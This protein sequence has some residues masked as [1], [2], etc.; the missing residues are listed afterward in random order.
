MDIYIDEYGTAHVTEYWDMDTNEGTENY[1]SYGNLGDSHISNFRVSVGNKEFEP[2]TYWDIDETFNYK[3]YKSG[4][5]HTSEGL[6]LCWGISEYGNMQYKLTYEISN[7]VINVADAQMIYWTLIPKK[8]DPAPY[9]YD[10]TIR[11][12]YYFEDSIDV[13]GYGVKGDYAYV[14]NGE[15]KLSNEDAM[16][17]SEYVVLLAKIPSGTFQTSSDLNNNFEYYLSMAQEGASK[18]NYLLDIFRFFII[19][20][21][22]YIL[23][24]LLV[25]KKSFNNQSKYTKLRYEG[26]S[27]KISKNNPLFREIPCEK[28]IYIASYIANA[29]K[30]DKNNSNFMGCL[31][32][33]WLKDSI[34]KIEKNDKG[35]NVIRFMY[36]VLPENYTLYDPE[37]ELFKWMY[38][39]SNNDVLEKKDFAWYCKTFYKDIL[40]WYD[41][42]YRVTREVL[43]SKGWIT[44]KSESSPLKINYRY[45]TP[46]LYEE[47]CKIDGLKKYLIEFSNIKEKAPIE[48]HLWQEYLIFA[49]LFGIADKV[50]KQFKDFYPEINEFAEFDYDTF[51]FIDR[52]AFTGYHSA[53]SARS[54]AMGYSSGGGGFSS[55]GGGGGSFGGGRGGGGSR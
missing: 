42:N 20:V 55:G 7:F 32:L 24:F 30:L 44:T 21:I 53:S 34:I 14:S 40:E 5:N 49:Q 33:K 52:L 54:A 10:I 28:D 2:L 15:I 3:A 26:V 36:K 37:R 11:A 27:S 45:A 31:L 9:N 8:M 48:V 23:I 29:Y 35:L 51:I 1:K 18:Y 19:G 43:I 39:A 46:K 25:A 4:I 50:A 16:K 47:A 17:S 12:N 13:W 38:G 22:P 6:E 41:D